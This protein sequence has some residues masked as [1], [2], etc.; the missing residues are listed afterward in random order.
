MFSFFDADFKQINAFAHS[1]EGSLEKEKF[2]EHCDRTLKY[3]DYFT[4]T[5]SL[6]PI[7]GNLVFE[8]DNTMDIE[9][10]L[11]MIRK[12]VYYHD[13]GKLTEK[14]Q[15]KLDGEKNKETHSDKSFYFIVYILLSLSLEEK[16]SQKEFFFFLLISYSVLKHHGKLKDVRNEIADLKFSFKKSKFSEI[17]KKLNVRI[18]N[19]IIGIMEDDFF[20]CMQEYEVKQIIEKISKSSN[21]M[22]VLTKLINSLL[23]SSDYYATA[24][25]RENKNFSLNVLNENISETIYNNFHNTKKIAE[26]ANFNYQINE[27]RKELRKL[28]VNEIENFNK[29]KESRLNILRSKIN[30]EAEDNLDL[31]L[32]KK[33]SANVFMMNVPTGGG[34][35][36]ISMRLAVKIMR[37]RSVKKL[38]YVFPFIN[39]I[40]QSYESI[41]RFTGEENITRLDSRFVNPIDN[42]ETDYEMS[43]DKHIDTLFFNKPVLMMSHVKFFDMLFRN[44]KNSNYNFFQIANSVVVI[45]EIQA[46]NDMIWTEVMTLINSIGKFLN[47]YFI[48]MSATLPKL[49]RLVENSKFSTIL[50]QDFRNEIFNSILF[51]RTQIIPKTDIGKDDVPE[52]IVSLIE[53]NNRKILVVLNRIIDSYN[54]YNELSENYFNYKDY[55]ILLLNSTIPVAK[56]KE[57]IE[58]SKTESKIILIATQSVEAGVDID[59]DVGLRAYSP[60]DSIV[61]VAGRIN[62]NSKKKLCK[63]Y[64]FPDDSS[65]NVYRK[66]NKSK[67]MKQNEKVFFSYDSTEEDSAI[68]EFYEKT[69][70]EIQKFFGNSFVAN[71]LSNLKTIN[72][73]KFSKIDKEIKLI[74][75]DTISLFIPFETEAVSLWEEY[76]SLFEGE[77]S[78]DNLLKIK[79]FRKKLTP[80]NINLFNYYTSKGKLSDVLYNEIKYGFYYCKD[81]EEYFN[82]KSGLNVEEFKKNVT[83]GRGEFF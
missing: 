31:I 44:D 30:V 17:T 16:L 6:T 37:E 12:I 23:I 49:Q 70:D 15:R 66:S 19:E 45:D 4:E 27:D 42:E 9:R 20:E 63:L 57:I 74:D 83:S 11:Y 81:W 21:A 77:N 5:F 22:F 10:T 38:Y 64:V 14:F 26:F 68:E 32:Q 55:E 56:R 54:L 18:D 2:F 59:F 65:S 39:I 67:I 35:T 47:I 24:D 78:F 80:F 53:E 52:I 34:K 60:L 29:S 69:I 76:C 1:S 40:E 48:V 82:I 25:Y 13:I 8:I 58:K 61:Q 73:L 75:G 33:D 79:S 50:N 72:E 28:T 7:I 71:P 36:N 62:R 41:S 3:Y 51:K 46:Y 43:F